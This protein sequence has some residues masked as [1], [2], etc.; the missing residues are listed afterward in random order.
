MNGKKAKALRAMA[1]YKGSGIGNSYTTV[2]NTQRTIPIYQ[3]T[4]TGPV[5]DMF[6]N[7]ILIGTHVSAGTTVLDSCTRK[8]YLSLKKVS[9]HSNL[10]TGG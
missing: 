3:H 9:S 8:L 10:L 1:G 4:A 7:R 2:A 5:L 6:G